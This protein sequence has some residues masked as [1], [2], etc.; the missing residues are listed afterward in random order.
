MNISCIVLCFIMLK[1]GIYQLV[2]YIS[3]N[4]NCREVKYV[5]RRKKKVDKCRLSLVE[6]TG[7]KV[8]RLLD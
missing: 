7:Y 5:C 8:V 3:F 2:I 6:E 4:W 1:T